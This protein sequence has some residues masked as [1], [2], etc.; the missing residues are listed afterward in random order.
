MHAVRVIGRVAVGG[1]SWCAARGGCDLPVAIPW[2]SVD[3][4]QVIPDGAV[5]MVGV[6]VLHQI[7]AEVARLGELDGPSVAIGELRVHLRVRAAGRKHLVDGIVSTTRS[8]SVAQVNVVRALV[9]NDRTA[10]S[11]ESTG[12]Q[13]GHA[14]KN[15]VDHC[16][17]RS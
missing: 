8:R 2:V 17:G 11:G 1:L 16:C 10:R 12:G 15:G 13:E 5:G 7:A 9:D 4:A 3:L 14:S 6:F